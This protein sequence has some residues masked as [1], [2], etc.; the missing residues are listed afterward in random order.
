MRAL[1]AVGL[2]LLALAAAC[3]GGE[4][5]VESLTAEELVARAYEAMTKTSFALFVEPEAPDPVPGQPP[6]SI[7]YGPPD[8]L[9]F[10]GRGYE[11]PSY[12][13]LVGKKTY[14]S[15]TGKRWAL[16]FHG[17]DHFARLHYDPRELLRIATDLEDGG[18]VDSQGKPQRLAIARLDIAKFVDEYL[19]NLELT[20]WVEIPD[21]PCRMCPLTFDRQRLEALG[22]RNPDGRGEHLFKGQDI[23]IWASNTRMRFEVRG[24]RE[25][26]PALKD[27]FR[28]VIEAYSVDP[29]VLDTAEVR[30]FDEHKDWE[31]VYG[32]SPPDMVRFWIDPRT[33]LISKMILHWDGWTTTEKLF[34]LDYGKFKLPKPEPS[35]LAKEADIVWK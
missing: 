32:P 25:L 27:E 19:T 35:L 20:L 26:T 29:A 12:L 7:K 8:L 21:P 16:S 31:R 17:G 10:T 2:L 1:V 4:R 14:T 11:Y 18:T 22:Y 13:F 33:F 6:Y 28:Q 15:D 24:V 34:F 30:I 23:Y 9:L 5:P 3:G